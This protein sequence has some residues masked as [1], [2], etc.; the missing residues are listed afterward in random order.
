MLIGP[1]IAFTPLGVREEMNENSKDK[2]VKNKANTVTKYL[3]TQQ[4]EETNVFGKL[5]K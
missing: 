2:N 4:A 5:M 3:T 1:T